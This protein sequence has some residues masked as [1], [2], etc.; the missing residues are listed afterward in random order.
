MDG[1]YEVF[2][3]EKILVLISP[4]SSSEAKKV[5]YVAG[6]VQ[7]STDF[8]FVYFPNK[9]YQSFLISVEDS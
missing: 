4:T 7:K 5:Q 9:N 3:K 1:M 6:A 8:F 2:R